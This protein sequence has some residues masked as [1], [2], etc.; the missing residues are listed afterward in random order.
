M[1]GL[2]AA[3][4]LRDLF[5]APHYCGSP[6]RLGVVSGFAAISVFGLLACLMVFAFLPHANLRP[7]LPREETTLPLHKIWPYLAI[8]LVIITCY[9]TV[10]PDLRASTYG[11]LWNGW[12]HCC[13]LNWPGAYSRCFSRLSRTDFNGG[14]VFQE[15]PRV[16]LRGGSAGIFFGLAMLPLSRDLL[17]MC[18]SMTVID[19]RSD[20]RHRQF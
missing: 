11:S 5:A 8:T 15:S 4:Q 19:L 13:Y 2:S 3:Y 6:G 18:F 14:A 12:R 20:F 9:T 17:A 16:M 1:G 7:A 10:L